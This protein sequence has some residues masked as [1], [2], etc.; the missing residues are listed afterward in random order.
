[1]SYLDKSSSKK[2]ARELKQHDQ[3]A[4]FCFEFGFHE[5]LP[6]YS[7]GLGILAGDHCKAASDMRLPFVA[8][9][10]L[11]RQGYFAQ[12][13]D[14]QGNQQVTYT[15]SD[16]EDLPVTPVLREDGTSVQ[17]SIELPQRN[18]IAKIW[19]VKIGHVILY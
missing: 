5:S 15:A 19:Q 16:F 14:S 9:G 12:I 11:Y 2:D 1:D 8:I 17:V 18:V 4:Y 6:I 10:L 3:I 13:I 7:G